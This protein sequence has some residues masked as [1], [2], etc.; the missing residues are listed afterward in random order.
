MRE[1][2]NE[3][4]I[5]STENIGGLCKACMGLAQKRAEATREA[6]KRYSEKQQDGCQRVLSGS[7]KEMET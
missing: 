7:G 5:E 6:A 1:C 2:I 4:C 3:D